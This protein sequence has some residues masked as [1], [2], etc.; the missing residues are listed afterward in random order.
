MI[1]QKL[2]EFTE[3]PLRVVDLLNEY[4]VAIFVKTPHRG[5]VELKF[6][7]TI[8]GLFG[9]K[10]EITK[11]GTQLINELKTLETESKEYLFKKWLSTN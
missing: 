8:Y 2:N 7:E 5:E 9:A 3:L 11:T 4:G 1:L 10:G 6:K